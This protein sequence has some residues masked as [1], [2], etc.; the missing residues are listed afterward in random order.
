[1]KVLITT[2]P[3]GKKNRLPLDLLEKSNIDYV[4][5][6]LGRKLTEN[7]LAEMVPDF[8]VIIA[9]T[10]SITDYVI[11]CGKKLKMISRVGIGLDSVDLISARNRGI[12]VSYTPDAPAPAVS[13]LTIGLMISLLRSVQISNMK[14]HNGSWNRYF[15]R[16]LS[17]CTIGIIGMGRIGSRVLHHLSGFGCKQI[18][19]NDIREN[20]NINE[21]EIIKWVEKENIYNEADIITLHLPLTKDTKNMICREELMTMKK[22]AIII[23]TSRGGII[24]E[25][26][27]YE[28]LKNDHLEGAAIDVFDNEPYS[29]NL[30]T[31][32]NCLLT[33]HMGSMSI[34]CRTR[35]EIEATEEALRFIK[36]KRMLS[37]V[38]EDEYSVQKEGL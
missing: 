9:G 3:F 13:E 36:N 7:E 21:S 1:M 17:E 26:D 27:L 34:D 16:R 6:P 28:V 35:M 2:V 24:N 22:D 12:A 10:E 29:G 14:I 11:E 37:C 32:D 38:P 23:N 5:N 30:Q 20:Y 19:L 18:L 8:D 33:A 25:N 15:G 4:I 31:I